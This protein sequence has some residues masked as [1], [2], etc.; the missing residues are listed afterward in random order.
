M[1]NTSPTKL[2]PFVRTLRQ[3][4]ESDDVV[5]PSDINKLSRASAQD[6]ADFRG[7]WSRIPLE[8]QRA[9]VN[10]MTEASELSIHSEFTDLF[11]ALLDD[12]DEFVRASAVDGLW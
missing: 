4:A 2:S 9:I 7:E 8:R 11:I 5:A 12:A 3:L 1:S 10:A 6:I